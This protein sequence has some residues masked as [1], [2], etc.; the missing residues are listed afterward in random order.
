MYPLA[1]KRSQ[2]TERPELL[3]TLERGYEIRKSKWHSLRTEN[4]SAV[5][6]RCKQAITST[7]GLHSDSY[8]LVENKEAK[9]CQDIRQMAF[10]L[11]LHLQNDSIY[12]L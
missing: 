4:T 12:C 10:S 5:N 3:H 11:E 7:I 1:T 6:K 9:G 8:A 2:K